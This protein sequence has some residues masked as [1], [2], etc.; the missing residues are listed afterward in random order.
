LQFIPESGLTAINS[1]LIESPE[2][3]HRAVI[4]TLLTP[5]LY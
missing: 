1:P 4:L 3:L 5:Q 2:T